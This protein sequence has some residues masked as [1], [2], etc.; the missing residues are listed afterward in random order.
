MGVGSAGCLMH[1]VLHGGCVALL[2]L[3]VHEQ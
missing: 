1:A 3:E 2:L